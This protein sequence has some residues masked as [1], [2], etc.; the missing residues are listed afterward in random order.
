MFTKVDVIAS[1]KVAL[2]TLVIGSV[3]C[4]SND[5]TTHVGARVGADAGIDA[6]AT[7]SYGTCSDAPPP[8]ATLAPDP[9]LYAGQCPVL[10][11]GTDFNPITSSGKDREFLLV[12]PD[13]LKP[14]E[15]LP[16]VFMW[17][18]VGGDAMQFYAI[19]G[20]QQAVNENRFIAVIPQGIGSFP[21]DWRGWYSLDPAS[22]ETEEFQ[23]FDDMLACVS[24]ELPVNKNCVSTAGVSDGALWSSQLIGGRGQYLSSAIILSGGVQNVDDSVDNALIR[25][26]IPAPHPMPVVVLWGGAKDIC[27]V[28]DFQPAT[29]A[30]E[31]A[32]V[33]ENH[34]IIECEHNCGH[35]VPPIPAPE[36][37]TS[38]GI[39]W[40][41]V[42]DH[43]YWLPT[44]SSP[45]QKTGLPDGWPSWCAIGA[46]KRRGKAG[47]GLREPRVSGG[48]G[49]GLGNAVKVRPIGRPCGLRDPVR[50][51]F[52]E[53]EHSELLD[54][55]S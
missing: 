31:Q 50:S 4:S 11:P 13:D 44:D 38:L 49:R 15:R 5:A 12:V 27:V 48:V 8:G 47:R 24:E 34:F 17:H 22:D 29:K 14:D 19:A 10:T 7:K 21:S 39:L 43:P 53:S 26:Y 54:V 42:Q 23:F 51:R 55:R 52:H 33:S 6:S 41:F 1:L 45:Y 28:L 16:L 18:W 46:G 2:L 25:P 37:G 32:L 3:G 20:A 35:S 30:L 9:P 40:K 36:G